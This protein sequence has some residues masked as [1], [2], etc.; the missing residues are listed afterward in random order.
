MVLGEE[1]KMQE[2]AGMDSH[3]VEG[4]VDASIPGLC[5]VN[6]TIDFPLD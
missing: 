3:G 2:E 4:V 5:G 6:K 1:H